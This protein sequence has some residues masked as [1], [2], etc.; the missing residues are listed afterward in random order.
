MYHNFFLNSYRFQ[1]LKNQ[2]DSLSHDSLDFTTCRISSERHFSKAVE[3][4]GKKWR[5]FNTNYAA[6]GKESRPDSV[7]GNGREITFEV[8]LNFTLI[9]APYKLMIPVIKLESL[10]PQ[11]QSQNQLNFYRRLHCGC[12]N[13][14][15][16]NTITN[17]IKRLRSYPEIRG[18]MWQAATRA[19]TNETKK[20]KL[21]KP[22]QP[23]Q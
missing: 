3:N 9:Q 16:N 6:C 23:L 21:A 19:K 4:N 11:F 15:P 20:A 18:E 14:G 13:F 7:L 5:C 17:N 10:S 1:Q 8:T 22:I 12:F 2:V